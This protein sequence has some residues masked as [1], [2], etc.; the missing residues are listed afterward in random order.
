MIRWPKETFTSE[1]LRGR[2]DNTKTDNVQMQVVLFMSRE[3]N[4]QFPPGKETDVNVSI[5]KTK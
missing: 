5:Q 3:Y 2:R 4:E 1:P